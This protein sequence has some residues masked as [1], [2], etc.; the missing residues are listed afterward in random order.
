MGGGGQSRLA[1][2]QIGCPSSPSL[3][4]CCDAPFLFRL[5]PACTHSVQP[6]PVKFSLALELGTRRELV[7]PGL[8][9]REVRVRLSGMPPDTPCGGAMASGPNA[10]P[11][12]A[13]PQREPPPGGLQQLTCPQANKE[14]LSPS[15]DVQSATS[16]WAPSVQCGY[17]WKAIHALPQ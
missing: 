12:L 2:S 4:L 9:S 6:A 16:R 14:P 3:W 1:S 5:V 10:G 15:P 8:G 7:S 13:L 11:A 17:S